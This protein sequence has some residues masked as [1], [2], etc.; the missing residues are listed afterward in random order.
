MFFNFYKN[1]WLLL[2]TF[3]VQYCRKR[4]RE[5]NFGLF[6]YTSFLVTK[7]CKSRPIPVRGC[8]LVI[9]YIC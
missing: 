4:I 5:Y 1:N 2:I 6:D 7:P 8:K 9:I 3:Y